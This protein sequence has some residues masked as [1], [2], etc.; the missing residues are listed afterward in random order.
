MQIGC[1]ETADSKAVLASKELC[2]KMYTSFGAMRETMEFLNEIEQVVLQALNK[3][4][5]VIG[6]GRVQ[7]RTRQTSVFYFSNYLDEK[8]EESPP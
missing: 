1:Y 5:Y 3:W 2:R 4:W 7:T 6:V 8:K